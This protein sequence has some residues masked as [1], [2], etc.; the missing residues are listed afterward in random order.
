MDVGNFSI[1]TQERI[2]GLE[3]VSQE[4][5]GKVCRFL[6]QSLVKGNSSVALEA[7]HEDA[8]CAVSTLL[9]EAAKQKSSVE[10]LGAV[11]RELGAG[12]EATGALT[13]LYAEHSELLVEHLSA[14]GI[15]APEVVGVDWRL[16]YSVK[17]S[18]GGRGNVAMFFVSLTV[19]DRGLLR[20]VGFIASIEELQDLLAKVKDAVKQT[21]RLL[22]HHADA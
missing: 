3:A 16:D 5:L 14:T 15:A 17:S 22:L 13:A 19:K 10:Q 18:C 12:E 9:L 7:A 8:L 11:L 1:K 6:M 2:S 21:D 4:S 20:E